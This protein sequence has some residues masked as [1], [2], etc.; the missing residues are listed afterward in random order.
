MV[1]GL[2]LNMKPY[3]GDH[4]PSEVVEIG[5]NYCTELLLFTELNIHFTESG[6]RKHDKTF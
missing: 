3:E 4:F 6:L 2:W 5:P 1:D